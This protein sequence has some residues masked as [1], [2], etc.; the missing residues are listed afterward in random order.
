VYAIRSRF[1]PSSILPKFDQ[2]SWAPGE[3]ADA[4]RTSG[5][6]PKI[7]LPAKAR[8]RFG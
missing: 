1:I 7:D 5:P 2:T 6:L 4:S 8:G 3:S